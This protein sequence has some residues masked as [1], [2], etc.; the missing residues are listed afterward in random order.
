[1][2]ELEAG[3]GPGRQRNRRPVA[4]DSTGREVACS[5]DREDTG[6]MDFPAYVW[7]GPLAIH[8]HWL[9]ESVAYLVGARVYAWNKARHGDPI[10]P[11]DR[12][13]VVAAAA[14]GAAIG[15]KLLYWASEPDV[16]LERWHDPFFLFGGKSIVG[17]LI[18][19]LIAVEWIKRRIGVTQSTGDLFAVPLAVGIAVGRV[20]CYLTGLDDHTYGLPTTLPWGVDFG[21]GVARHPTQL[22]EIGSSLFLPPSIPRVACRRSRPPAD[23]FKLFLVASF[24]SRCVVGGIKPGV[25]LARLNAIQWCCLA[26]L[27]YYGPRIVPRRGRREVVPSEVLHG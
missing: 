9:F 21:D 19:A 15:G 25:S 13:S 6:S 5:A 2:T 14:V 23:L 24:G 12:W 7:L 8:P 20:G 26:M 27:V 22:Y 10:A 4:V 16:M 1:M 17:S 11:P 18:G 3:G